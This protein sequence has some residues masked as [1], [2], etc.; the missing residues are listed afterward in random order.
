MPAYLRRTAISGARVPAQTTRRDAAGEQLEVGVPDP[1]D[2]AAV[3]D[4]V[5][6]GDPEVDA[7]RRRA[8]RL[9]A[10]RAQHLVR[11]GRVLDQQDRD[12]LARRP[13][14]S[15][16]ART[17]VS[18][19]SSAAYRRRRGGS[20]GAA[21]RSAPR[22]R[23]RRC[24]G[25]GAGARSRRRPRACGPDTVEPVHAAQL[26]RARPRRRAR[27]G[28]RRSSGTSS[29]RGARRRPARRSRARRNGGSAWRR[30]RA[31][32]RAAP[33]RRPRSRSR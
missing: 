8:R 23:C 21:P 16:P 30:G 15:R 19:L 31:G 22:A 7:R 27:A 6:E 2:V 3:G 18:A 13:R 26:D 4:L 25:R 24:R 32:A 29:G 14:R 11:A 10:Q 33:A 17:R 1:G 20:R 28:R 5:V 9:E 12:R